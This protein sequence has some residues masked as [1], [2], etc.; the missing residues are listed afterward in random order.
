MS[1]NAVRNIILSSLSKGGYC[2][3]EQLGQNAGV[4]R[5]AIQKH[6]VA[7]Q[8]LGLDIYSVKGKGYKLASAYTSLNSETIR[9]LA[10]L[11][12]HQ[13][14]E[15]L[16]VVD[17]T[18]DYLKSRVSDLTD[19]HTCLTEAQTGGKG[20]HGRVWHSPFGSNLYLTMYWRF[21]D[22]FQA[23]AGLSLCVGVALLRGL[24]ALDFNFAQLKWPND[25][26]V[27]GKK[28]AGVLVEAESLPD[29]SCAAVIGIGLN[30]NMNAEVPGSIG[31]PWTSLSTIVERELDRNAVAASI[32]TE[33]HR[34]LPTFNEFGFEPFKNEWWQ[35]NY[36]ADKPICI[37]QGKSQI[38]GINSGV[39]ETGALVLNCVDE[40]GKAQIR[41]FHGGEV[42]VRQ[43]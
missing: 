5:A 2:S 40:Q 7:L 42:S 20:R 26:L 27:E 6:V 3:G 31:Q 38:E 21:P 18:N 12:L 16:Q 14:I 11:G 34:V 10:G 28:L 39:T 43:K 37:V 8:G 33:L 22:G 23:M 30:V 15:V 17:S 35:A 9:E 4:T 36:Y 1:E 24:R 32:I 25:I 41:H 13:E 29:T 19:G